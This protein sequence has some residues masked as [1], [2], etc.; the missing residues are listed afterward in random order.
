MKPPNI[1]D[2]A[3]SELSQDAFICWLLS[4]AKNPSSDPMHQVGQDFVKLL[5]NGFIHRDKAIRNTQKHDD[6]LV[7]VL[8]VKPQSVFKIDVFFTAEI[9]GKLYCFIIED[10][11]NSKPHSDQLKRYAEQV[12]K[13]G[14]YGALKQIRIY[15]KTGYVYEDEKTTCSENEADYW[16]LD[17]YS[18]HEFLEAYDVDNLVF[19][20]YKAFIKSK[21]DNRNEL[22]SNLYNGNKDLGYLNKGIAQYEFL[23]RLK[24]S[25]LKQPCE[26]ILSNGSS[27]GKP[28]AQLR[29]YTAF[30]VYADKAEHIFYRV[31]R[32][33]NG[34]CITLRQYANIDKKNKLFI[35]TKKER[36]K[37]YKAIVRKAIDKSNIEAELK[38][39]KYQSD[40]KGSKSSQMMLVYFKENSVDNILKYLPL[41]NKSFVELVNQSTLMN[42][43]HTQFE[44]L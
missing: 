44:K 40:G 19:N 43:T 31:E 27:S 25:C 42:K 10:K 29:L 15:F 34:V 3:T 39:G 6:L 21:L 8:D 2:Y 26:F 17:I 36:L 32:F 4:Y 23:K 9:L 30:N 7:K 28:Y 33:A 41:F 18:L 22:L 37:Q 5:F 14:T 38:L 13:H 11:T 24:S 12:D 16:I 1:F 35:D 20:S